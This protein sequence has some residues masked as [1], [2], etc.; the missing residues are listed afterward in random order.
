MIKRSRDVRDLYEELK[1][2]HD[3]NKK[4][5]QKKE[6]QRLK[7]LKKKMNALKREITTLSLDYD[8]FSRIIADR[9]IESSIHGETYGTYS[10]SVRLQGKGTPITPTVF[11]ECASLKKLIEFAGKNYIQPECIKLQT[12]AVDLELD[13]FI[14]RWNEENPNILMNRRGS[15][16]FAYADVFLDITWRFS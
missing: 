10:F 16:V 12:H 8:D 4:Q 5:V 3:K 7:E 1:S 2:L 6:T 9:L 15:F 11:E 13:T 14:T